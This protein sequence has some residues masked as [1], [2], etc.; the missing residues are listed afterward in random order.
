MLETNRE[1]LSAAESNLKG[2]RYE[3]HSGVDLVNREVAEYGLHTLRVSSE[4]RDFFNRV[5]PR[6]NFVSNF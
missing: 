1:R 5:E 6:I 2:K 3:V 4:E